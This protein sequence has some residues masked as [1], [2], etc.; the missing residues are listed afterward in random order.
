MSPSGVALGGT[1]TS[2]DAVLVSLA[3]TTTDA[4]PTE[5]YSSKVE[6]KVNDD[7]VLVT[8]TT[9]VTMPIGHHLGASPCDEVVAEPVY[10]DEG[11][12][13]TGG[14]G[15][16]YEESMGDSPVVG[17]SVEVAD[18]G[19][20]DGVNRSVGKRS[21]RTVEMV[22][23]AEAAGGKRLGKTLSSSKTNLKN[24]GKKA[25]PSSLAGK[26]LEI[27]VSSISNNDVRNCNNRYWLENKESEAQKIWN[28]GKDLGFSFAGK[29]EVVVK[30]LQSLEARDR[31]NMLLKRKGSVVSDDE[32][33]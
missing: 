19:E 29:E 28:I 7:I 18:G 30:N 24:M 8:S 5:G 26:R 32:N 2:D 4:L 12:E 14:R 25:A 13:V 20:L 17:G 15:I 21:V 33:N 22:F 23:S 9:T 1:T 31:D 16:G 10:R 11:L 27:I 3:P 6:I